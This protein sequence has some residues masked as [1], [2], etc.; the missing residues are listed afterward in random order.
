M[1]KMKSFLCYVGIS[2]LIGLCYFFVTGFYYFRHNPP[3]GLCIL[4]FAASVF[5]GLMLWLYP[6][7]A[8]SRRSLRHAGLAVAMA[9][10]GFGV[11]W[12]MWRC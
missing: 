5:A 12:S 7:F 10:F 2:W 8:A 4:L 11:L 1:D 9:S 3:D 6:V